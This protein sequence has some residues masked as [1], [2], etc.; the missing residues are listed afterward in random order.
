MSMHIKFE[1]YQLSMYINYFLI[2][3]QLD[4]ELTKPGGRSHSKII[5]IVK[6]AAMCAKCVLPL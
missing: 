6:S 4:Y 1:N 5:C 3:K 2:V